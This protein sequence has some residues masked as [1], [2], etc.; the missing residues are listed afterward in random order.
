[1]NRVSLPHTLALSHAPL[2]SLA[3]GI[4]IGVCAVFVPPN[5]LALI[6]VLGFVS[7]Y[8]LTRPL[9]GLSV[10]LIVSPLRTLILTES[11]WP[12]PVDIGQ[13]IFILAV[14]G[15]SIQSWL[16]SKPKLTSRNNPLE[17]AILIFIVMSGAGV[18]FSP[19]MTSWMSEWIKWWQILFIVHII[20][21]FLNGTK[22]H[23]AAIAL[24]VA[25]LANAIIGIYQFFGGSGALHLLID[26]HFFRAF[27]TFG[28]P[29]PFGGFMG[30]TLPLMVMLLLFNLRK[31]WIERISGKHL[32]LVGL[33]TPVFFAGVAVLQSIAIVMSWSRGAWLGVIGALMAMVILLPRKMV[34]SLLILL[35]LGTFLVLIVTNDLL[36]DTIVDRIESSLSE[37]VV[38]GDVR[39]VDI[40]PE[41]F[42]S[43]ERLAHWQA[44]LKMTT[45]SPW[46][47]VGFGNFEQSYDDFRLL[48]WTMGLGHAHNYYLNL[49]AEVGLFGL[50]GYSIVWIVIIHMS[51]KVICHP[52]G[53]IRLVGVGLMGSWVYFAIHS[54]FDN[55]YVNNLFFQLASMLSILIVLYNQSQ[56]YSK[57]IYLDESG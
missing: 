45:V 51:W 17:V 46:L 43:I 32:E 13:L 19:S 35:I 53:G 4:A 18:F 27:G 40:T 41:N 2:G 21:R 38:A 31:L 5:W 34:Y 42:A 33:A 26:N 14:V 9:A 8:L 20:S 49:L 15:W 57:W 56:S 10:L 37:L 29:N 48:N 11:V 25:V 55:L 28:Q 47:G 16:C 23:W 12:F 44:A 24:A 1:M 6:L 22:W 36:P 7:S 30:L 39:G 50:I 54:F 52:D 3:I